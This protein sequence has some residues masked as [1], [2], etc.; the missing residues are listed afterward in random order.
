V[1]RYWGAMSEENVELV[2]RLFERFQA[3]MERGDPNAGLD[4]GAFAEDF[5]WIVP[6]PWTAGLSRS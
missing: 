2:R 3:A 4:P 5:E 6:T 1:A